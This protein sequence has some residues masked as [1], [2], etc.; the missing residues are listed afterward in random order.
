MIIVIT[1]KAGKGLKMRDKPV[2]WLSRSAKSDILMVIAHIY[3][4][5]R[6]GWQR[7]ENARHTC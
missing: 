4:N 3:C 5:N 7:I 2:E 1:G 6:Q